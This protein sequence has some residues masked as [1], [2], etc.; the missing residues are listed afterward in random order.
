MRTAQTEVR[1]LLA[2]LQAYALVCNHVRFSCINTLA[3]GGRQPLLQTEGGVGGMRSAIASVFGAKQLAELIP[4]TGS[5]GTVTLC[6]FVSRP[7]AGYGR[8]VCALSVN[9]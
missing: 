7:R 1:K 3:K 8:C 2:S 6:G 4:L 5:T 9:R